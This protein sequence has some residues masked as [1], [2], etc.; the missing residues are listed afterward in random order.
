[1]TSLGAGLVVFA[2][3]WTPMRM[4]CGGQSPVR[5]LGREKKKRKGPDEE[6]ITF[7]RDKKL[8]EDGP[9]K[10]VRYFGPSDWAEEL[11]QV[12][13]IAAKNRQATKQF[14]DSAKGYANQLQEEGTTHHIL[15]SAVAGASGVGLAKMTPALVEQLVEE[16]ELDDQ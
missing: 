15:D 7:V 14:K 12:K 13:E 11:V 9:G 5:E 1:M 3:K 4:N 16:G 10:H 2:I 6:T 8:H